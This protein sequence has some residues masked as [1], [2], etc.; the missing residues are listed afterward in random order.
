MSQKYI[1]RVEV[2]CNGQNITD[3]RGFTENA[4]VRAK[5]VHLMHSAD[6]LAD[7]AIK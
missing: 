1:I 5:A 3:F 4:V 2:A 6:Y 7:I